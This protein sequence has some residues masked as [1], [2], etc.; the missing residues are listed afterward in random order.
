MPSTAN[1]SED[2]KLKNKLHLY[3][4]K[5]KEEEEEGEEE[6]GK[7]EGEIERNVKR[8]KV[9]DLWNLEKS[10]RYPAWIIM[11]IKR[12]EIKMTGR[13]MALVTHAEAGV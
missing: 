5:K 9:G 13:L 4:K 6:G 1:S 8:R 3:F 10:W 7:A 12:N 11:I 2:T